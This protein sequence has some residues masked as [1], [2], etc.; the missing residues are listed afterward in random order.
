MSLL[1]GYMTRFAAVHLQSI[2]YDLRIIHLRHILYCG[3]GLVFWKYGSSLAGM[4]FRVRS[5]QGSIALIQVNERRIRYNW[6][7]HLRIYTKK[8]HVR[9][10]LAGSAKCLRLLCNLLKAA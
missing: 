7:N 5:R 1:E 10:V 4:D 2:A 9:P 3:T 8:K 6:C